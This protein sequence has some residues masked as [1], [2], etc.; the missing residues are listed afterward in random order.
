[1]FYNTLQYFKR[2]LGNLLITEEEQNYFQFPLYCMFSIFI[3]EWKKTG[4]RGIWYDSI[5]SESVITDSCLMIFPVL[6]YRKK[7]MFIIIPFMN[8]YDSTNLLNI[9]GKANSKCKYFTNDLFLL[10]VPSIVYPIVYPISIQK[11]LIAVIVFSQLR[12][13]CFNTNNSHQHRMSTYIS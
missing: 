6:W 8:Q 3:Y 10:Y 4:V 12:A 7:K 1:M 13:Q 2:T 11:G 9:L 5:A